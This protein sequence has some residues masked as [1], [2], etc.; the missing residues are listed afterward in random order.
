MAKKT[1]PAEEAKKIQAEIDALK[2]KA[3]ILDA[4]AGQSQY[5][6]IFKRH[7]YFSIDTAIGEEKWD[8]SNLDIIGDI[9]NI[10][11]KDNVYDVIISTQ[12][13]EHV[14]E[15]EKLIKESYRVLKRGGSLYMSAPQ[16]WGVHQAPHAD[17][18]RQGGKRRNAW[19]CLFAPAGPNAPSARRAAPN[20]RAT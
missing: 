19:L 14:K 17:R 12:V 3:K 18:H 1:T 7:K 16:G 4:G 2:E 9:C 11:I 6:Y 5:K 8:Y 13:L 20:G 10:P 15:P